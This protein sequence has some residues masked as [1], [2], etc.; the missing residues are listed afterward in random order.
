MR[1]PRNRLQRGSSPRMRGALE[2]PIHV[3]KDRGIIPAYAGSTCGHRS[4][5]QIL[6]DHP[7][8]CGEHRVQGREVHHRRG[9]SPRM[10]GARFRGCASCRSTGI[11]PAYAGSTVNND[12]GR[13]ADQD[14]PRVCG[15]HGDQQGSQHEV[16]GSSPRMRGALCK[17]ADGKP[18]WRI[19]PAYAGS[20]AGLMIKNLRERDHPRVC[21]EHT[22]WL[23][24]LSNMTGSSP[25]MRGAPHGSDPP[26]S[27]IRIIP[28]YA[29]STLCARRARGGGGD[30]PRVCGEHGQQ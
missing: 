16:S 5:R 13:V 3:V 12:Q 29:G 30:H 1:K 4:H 8:V 7:R 21:G 2:L 24:C 26:L 18:P 23:A 6:R 17:H 27:L 25:R 22:F 19:I 28:A 15:E 20:T 10:R 9:S 14:H 11:I